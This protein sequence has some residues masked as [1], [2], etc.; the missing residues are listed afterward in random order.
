MEKTMGTKSVTFARASERTSA[1]SAT[2]VQSLYVHAACARR[3][4]GARPAD[5]RH[6]GH[7]NCHGPRDG[8]STVRARSPARPSFPPCRYA[9][10]PPRVHALPVDMAPV[11]SC[12]LW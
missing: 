5:A 10:L 1:T 3:R 11:R 8:L 12:R 9:L 2:W 6:S 7:G 4:P